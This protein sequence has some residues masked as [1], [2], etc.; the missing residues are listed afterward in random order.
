V[1]QVI[2]SD[3]WRA[4]RTHL[5]GFLFAL[6]LWV[7]YELL[8]LRMNDGWGGEYRTG[9]DY[10]LKKS[11]ELFSLPPWLFSVAI[12]TCLTVFFF[13]NKKKLSLPR[14]KPFYFGLMFLESML[15]GSLLGL[16]VGSFMTIFLSQRL[17]INEQR[18]RDLIINLGSG[19]YE[20]LIFR[21]VLLSLLVLAFRKLMKTHQFIIY[22]NAI[23][24]SSLLFSI[25]HYMDIFL[26]P[27][28]TQSFVFRFLAGILFALIFMFRG[29]GIAAYSH[30][31]YNIF[32][33]FR[34][35]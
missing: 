16:A 28:T 20:E 5:F 21:L 33:F 14:R 10:L 19:V 34:S 11:F 32:L 7:G 18:I 4:S 3:Y 17:V 25:Y 13:Q 1:I 30:S 12:L 9:T 15:Y 27:F 22:F 24:I 26:E 6:P 8:A 2:K 23:I 29:Y 35:S 31:F